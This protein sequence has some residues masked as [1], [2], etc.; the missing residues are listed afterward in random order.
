MSRLRHVR[1]EGYRSIRSLAVPLGNRT[2]VTGGNGAGKTNF[3]RSL[4]LVHAAASGTLAQAIADEGGMRSVLWAG[5][6]GAGPAE[7][8][9]LEADLDGLRY[10]LRLGIPGPN[11]PALAL[12][13]MVREESVAARL[14]DRAPLMM[15]RK[16]P[17]ITARAPDGKW[18]PYPNMLLMAETALARLRDPVR[19]PELDALQ[20]RFAAWR[21]HH[22]FRTDE[23]SPLRWP[24]VAI[25]APMLDGDGRNLA[26]TL[27]TAVHLGDDA[28][29]RTIEAAIHA[30]FPGSA[31]TFTEAAG[32][33][34]VALS[35]P[36]FSRPF[37][38]HEMSDGTLRYLCL[39][40]AL[41]SHRHPP[42]IALNEPEA[43]LH[44]D[45]I[46]PLAAMILHAS[47][48]TQLV[49]V[50]HSS[51]LADIL[52]ARGD[53][54]RIA[55]EKHRGATVVAEDRESRVRA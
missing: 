14:G 47:A 18:Q 43:S 11:D 49:V 12:D 44:D 30:A 10:A 4:A 21:F 6:D 19:F 23:G 8:I 17:N 37:S 13:P 50:T 54:T 33:H 9:V 45:L 16:G 25:C 34:A 36:G 31:L 35:M 7:S 24:Q 3:Y 22:G 1:V 42:F 32:R 51:A 48:R 29:R 26:A 28:A 46:E 55:L 39:I 2:V 52:E 41:C 53:T 15:Q 27:A 40:A 38:A 20:R 5:A